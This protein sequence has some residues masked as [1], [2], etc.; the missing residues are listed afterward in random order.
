[1]GDAAKEAFLSHYK[2][3][4]SGI[5]CCFYPV[6]PSRDLSQFFKHFCWIQSVVTLEKRVMELERLLADSRR[7]ENTLAKQ[8]K[9]LAKN[10]EDLK[11]MLQSFKSSK[12]K[13][14][15]EFKTPPSLRF[16]N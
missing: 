16:V 14:K 12:D 3:S 2:V 4:G 11:K 5:I 6:V 1:M 13:N 8:H 15:G 9:E 7:N 10:S